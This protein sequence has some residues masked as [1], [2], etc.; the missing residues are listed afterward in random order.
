MLKGVVDGND[1]VDIYIHLLE[2]ESEIVQMAGLP[3][4][5]TQAELIFPQT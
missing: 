3:K 1:Q 5:S 4:Q 2:F